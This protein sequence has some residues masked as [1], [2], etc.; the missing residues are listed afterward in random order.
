MASP[1]RV[2]EHILCSCRYLTKFKVRRPKE[3][4]EGSQEPHRI[5]DSWLW[6]CAGALV[7]MLCLHMLSQPLLSGCAMICCRTSLL[8]ASS[9]TACSSH[10]QDPLSILQH[11]V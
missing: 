6:N 11:T 9:K 7:E 3:L 10:L 8:P 2:S 4:Q 1:V 5:L